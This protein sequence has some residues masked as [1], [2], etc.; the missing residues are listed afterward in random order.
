MERRQTPA[1]KGEHVLDA[2]PKTNVINFAG[3]DGGT[4]MRLTTVAGASSDCRT[5]LNQATFL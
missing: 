5:L 3:L 4:E 2:A 1:Q